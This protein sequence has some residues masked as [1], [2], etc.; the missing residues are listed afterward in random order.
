MVSDLCAM[1]YALY[2]CTCACT[3]PSG[4]GRQVG[5]RRPSPQVEDSLLQRRTRTYTR[6]Y[7]PASCLSLDAPPPTPPG[8]GRTQDSADLPGVDLWGRE[9]NRR[10]A[11]VTGACRRDLERCGRCVRLERRLGHE[12]QRR[13]PRLGPDGGSA[14]GPY[15]GVSDAAVACS[16]PR[17]ATRQRL[18][19]LVGRRLGGGP[20]RPR[21]VAETCCGVL[22]PFWILF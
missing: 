9:P 4:T 2:L 15:P 20:T 17:V 5:N 3:P 21:V 7:Q 6:K 22:V 16:S 13:R 8:G 1:C 14:A 12:V 19:S 10:V 18:V 11:I